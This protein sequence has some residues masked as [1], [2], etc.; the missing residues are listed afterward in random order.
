MSRFSNFCLLTLQKILYR[1][2]KPTSRPQ[3]GR[4][5]PA[6]KLNQ[7][8]VNASC[9]TLKCKTDLIQAGSSTMMVAQTEIERAA[10]E[11]HNDSNCRILKLPLSVRKIIYEKIKD[12]AFYETRHVS[13]HRD[14]QQAA[15]IFNLSKVC[16]ALFSDVFPM[17]YGDGLNFD[18]CYVGDVNA[19]PAE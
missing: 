10:R 19:S 6:L 1:T 9:S 18:L 14:R 2:K 5:Q 4:W 17:I 15:D 11:H 12:K 16:R 7:W 13:C 8:F 3:K